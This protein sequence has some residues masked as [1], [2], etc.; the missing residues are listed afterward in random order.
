MDKKKLKF[1]LRTSKNRKKL[2]TFN[3]DEWEFLIKIKG[4][5]LNMTEKKK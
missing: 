4:L 5:S 1:K 2:R 3:I